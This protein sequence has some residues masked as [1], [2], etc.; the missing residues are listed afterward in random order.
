MGIKDELGARS[1]PVV[2]VRRD[3]V[4]TAVRMGLRDCDLRLPERAIDAITQQVVNAYVTPSAASAVPQKAEP[5]E[6]I[7]SY[8]TIRQS[9]AIESLLNNG[10]RD[11]AQFHRDVSF[12]LGYGTKEERQAVA[13]KVHEFG[14]KDVD[15][16]EFPPKPLPAVPMQDALTTEKK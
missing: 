14:G 6:L 10:E 4:M 7:G 2:K 12:I 9:E 15:R 5:D 11:Y 8:D 3:V 16:S 13:Q 1:V